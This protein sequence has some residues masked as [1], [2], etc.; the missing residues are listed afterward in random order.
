MVLDIQQTQNA[1]DKVKNAYVQEPKNFVSEQ[2]SSICIKI[3]LYKI[4]H[5]TWKFPFDKIYELNIRKK[6]PNTK[7]QILLEKKK[8]HHDPYKRL[9]YVHCH[10]ILKTTILYCFTSAKID[11]HTVLL[12][13]FI[14][15]KLNNRHRSLSITEHLAAKLNDR[16]FFPMENIAC[17]LRRNLIIDIRTR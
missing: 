8:H 4:N 10:L 14:K 6:S 16:I 17:A 12:A 9:H 13:L 7:D 5:Y 1:R 2:N 15:R 11:R 3:I